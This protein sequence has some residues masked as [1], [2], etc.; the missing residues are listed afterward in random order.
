M[1]SFKK[2]DSTLDSQEPFANNN[3]TNTYTNNAKSV[4]Q[5]STARLIGIACTCALTA[6]H[7]GYAISSINVPSNVFINC[8]DFNQESSFYGLTGCFTVSSGY[9]GLVGMGLPLGGWIGGL[10]GPSLINLF[11]GIKSSILFLNVPITLAYFFMSLAI[12]L[13]MLIVGR[14]LLGF[15][16]GA[17]G[18]L[19]PLYLSSIAPLKLRGIFTNFFVLFLCLSVFVAELISYF[20]DT[21]NHLWVWRFTFAAGA[22]VVLLQMILTVACGLFPES[23]LDIAKAKENYKKPDSPVVPELAKQSPYTTMDLLTFKIPEARKSLAL[24]IILHAGQQ[25]SGV[26]AI[27]FY[28]SMIIGKSPLAPVLLTFVNLVM[29]VLAIWLLEQAG[30]R[31]VAIFS[32]AGSS[33]CL[34]GLAASFA[35]FPSF[36]PFFAIAFVAVYSVGLGPIPWLVVSEIFPASWPLTTAAISICVSANW[37]PNILVS[38]GFP[39]VAEFISKEIIFAFFGIICTALLIC[40]IRFLPETRNRVANFI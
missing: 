9:W 27:F 22:L 19:V 28:S 40:L 13:P 36:A 26:T 10:V 31:P 7:F 5:S 37:I 16:A 34:L 2:S 14:C 11:G 21:G 15:A 30:R 24:G 17:S 35:M 23:P 12:N 6:F 4:D 25:L 39:L 33:V 29:T 3:N 38:G 8:S 1:K 18:M 20:C 32:V